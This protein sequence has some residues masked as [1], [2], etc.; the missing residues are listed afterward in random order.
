MECNVC[1]ENYNDGKRLPRTLYCGHTLCTQCLTQI[2]KSRPLKCPYC[3]ASNHRG[4]VLCP[5]DIPLHEELVTKLSEK[6]EDNEED[7][8]DGPEGYKLSVLKLREDIRKAS[9]DG[10]YLW[11]LLAAQGGQT[12]HSR[13]SLLNNRLHLHV[14]QEGVPPSGPHTV[15][16]KTGITSDLKI[17]IFVLLHRYRQRQI[18]PLSES[19]TPWA[20]PIRRKAS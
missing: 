6:G 14:L 11:T 19:I 2:M 5:A 8:A 16:S 4:T 7:K 12:R 9:A 13:V 15:S 10:Q 1:L 17:R 18:L 20:M 3:R